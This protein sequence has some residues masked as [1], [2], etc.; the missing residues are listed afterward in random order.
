MTVSRVLLSVILALAAIV[1]NCAC[2]TERDLNEIRGTH[3]N[4]IV[5][6]INLPKSQTATVPIM[7]YIDIQTTPQDKTA[8]SRTAPTAPYTSADRER[9]RQPL[10]RKKYQPYLPPYPPYSSMLPPYAPGHSY[11]SW[12]PY[13]P[14][15]GGP[16][17]MPQMMKPNRP[18]SSKIDIPETEPPKKP[19]M[20]EMLMSS[21]VK[22]RINLAV[23]EN[24]PMGPSEEPALPT[25]RQ[26][27][28]KK[29][30]TPAPPAEKKHVHPK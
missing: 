10:G 24:L 30:P 14:V 12:P 28:P 26:G 4:A 1:N 27:A 20:Q 19:K 29:S 17:E 21:P 8:R 7:I 13:Y 25:P 11:M 6:K 3:E 22:Q 23:S 5:R 15:M 9:V 2:L 16:D 18:R